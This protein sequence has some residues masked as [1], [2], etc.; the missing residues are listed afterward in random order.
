MRPGWLT[1]ELH[2]T[3]AVV[4]LAAYAIERGV[5]WPGAACVLAAGSASAA[6]SW[7]RSRLKAVEAPGRAVAERENSG[8]SEVG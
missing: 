2:G 7:G 1:S 4:A 8:G 5:G 6:Y 3:L